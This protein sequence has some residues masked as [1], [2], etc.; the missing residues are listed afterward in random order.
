MCGIEIVIFILVTLS[1]HFS[2]LWPKFEARGVQPSDVKQAE[3]VKTDSARIVNNGFRV[4]LSKV[5]K[6]IN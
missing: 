6:N 4:R 1:D 5:L 3:Y 2:S